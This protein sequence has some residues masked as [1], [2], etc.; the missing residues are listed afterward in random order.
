ME[1]VL[2]ILVVLLA[3]ASLV[4]ALL[5][6]KRNDG[7]A[8]SDAML[9]RI[10]VSEEKLTS[11]LVASSAD[12]AGRLERVKGE[13][14][15]DLSDRIAADAL[16]LRQAIGELLLAGRTEQDA[17]LRDTV[18]RLETKFDAL[19]T[20][21]ATASRDSRQEL[22]AGVTQ[23]RTELTAGM[24]QARQELT[25]GLVTTTKA[26]EEKLL[27]VETRTGNALDAIRTKVEERLGEI[28]KH[29]QEKLDQNIKEGFAQFEKVQ[30]HLRAAEEQLRNVGVL[31]AS[32]NDLNNLLKLPHLRGRF[33]EESLE[34]LI[35]DFLPTHMY[36]FQTSTG[37]GRGRPDVIIKLNDRTLP[38]DSKFPRE[39]VLA[40]FESN[41]P[42]KLD[43]AR[44]ALE[45][46]I[47]EQAKRIA[48]YIDVEAGT[49]NVALI[50]LPSETL[51]FEVTQNRDLSDWL[52]K[53]RVFPVSPNTLLLALHS[54]SLTYKWYQAAKGFEQTVRE[55][56]A[57]RKSF[58][59]FKGRFEEVGKALQK[60]QD[61]YST[62]TTHLTRY[63]SRVNTMTAD[64]QIGESPAPTD[65]TIPV[66]PIRTE[67][68][69]SSP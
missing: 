25:N 10:A 21:Q 23:S 32:I 26:L 38:I 56:S 45:R 39:Q 37:E 29:V 16:A 54:I 15:Q 60:A 41:D 27:G 14:R 59:F 55:L 4:V 1:L 31:G 48:A 51:W 17:R 53:N 46:A 13:L 36:E 44:A 67:G 11:Q 30:L 64:A 61:A 58:E 34:R 5:L 47:K 66:L 42:A 62:A 2:L 28:G 65:A 57:A 35:A 68:E 40:L 20:Q 63:D 3:A 52:A 43:E 19:A 7:A 12:A 6:L 50:Y 8:A 18:T 22:L 69:T 24:T 49:T 33:G 9:Q